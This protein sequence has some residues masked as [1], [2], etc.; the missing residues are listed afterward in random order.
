MGILRDDDGVPMRHLPSLFIP[1]NI[2]Q[3]SILLSFVQYQ[4]G[5][6]SL[7]ASTLYYYAKPCAHNI[8]SLTVSPSKLH[9]TLYTVQCTLCTVLRFS[10]V[11]LF[12]DP[13]SGIFF[14]PSQDTV[15][16]DLS[17]QIQPLSTP[18]RSVHWFICIFLIKKVIF[19]VVIPSRNF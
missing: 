18:C 16:I 15:G 9:C 17:H 4:R 3:D 12:T 11:F 14:V 6:V 13:L 1:M 19:T 5:C 8:R 2:L 7:D 10:I